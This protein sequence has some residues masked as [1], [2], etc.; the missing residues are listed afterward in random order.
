M[1]MLARFAMFGAVALASACAP[2]T[3]N[4]PVER[5]RAPAATPP[6]KPD[7]DAAFAPMPYT[8]AQIRAASGTGRTITFV[9]EAPDKPP[10][11]K[12]I[13]FVASDDEHA[14]L[15]SEILDADGK[16]VGEPEMSIAS[17]DEL[18]HHAAYP[19]ATTT[20]VDAVAE[21]PGGSFKCRRY[22]VIEKTPEGDKRTI[23]CFANELPGPPVEMSVEVGGALVMSMSLL[24]NEPGG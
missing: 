3:R 23:A 19:K 7:P 5:P 21:T 20:I 13:R 12:R 15:K 17:W 16:V 9:I 22:T 24:K 8:A 11:R 6:E 10:S 1:R 14:T 4:E 18:R 2:S